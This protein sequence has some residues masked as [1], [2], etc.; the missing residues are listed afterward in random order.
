[1]EEVKVD[2]ENANKL[3][4]KLGKL[5][6]HMDLV[7]VKQRDPYIAQDATPQ[8]FPKRQSCMILQYGFPGIGTI[9]IPIA[10]NRVEF[11]YMEG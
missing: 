10:A 6:F 3:N 8:G 2:G 5:E 7:S 4:I 1:M 11:R 9:T